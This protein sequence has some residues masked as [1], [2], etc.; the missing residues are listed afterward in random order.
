M[1]LDLV[2]KDLDTVEGLFSYIQ[3]LEYGELHFKHDPETGLKAFV[4]IHNTNLGPSLGGCRCIPYPSTANAIVDALRLAR[5]MTYKNA[6]SG[7]ALGGGKAVIIRPE[8]IADEKAYFESF[9]QFVNDL[10]G[11]YITAKDSGTSMENLDIIA[12]KTPFIA[13]TT[14]MTGENGDPSPFTARGVCRGIEAAVKFKLKRESL[15]GIHVAIQGVGG[16]GYYLALELHNRG[17]KLTIS[18]INHDAV[19]RCVEEF[20]ADVV[21]TK[22]I[23]SLECDVLTPCALGATIN[24]K[25]IPLIK[26]PIIAGGANNQLAEASDCQSLVERGI[27]FA[28]D[29][30]IN[31]GGVIHAAGKYLETPDEESENKISAIYD[32]LLTIFDRA[33][34]EQKTTCE[35]ADTMA[36]EIFQ[37]KL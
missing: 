12:S 11:R 23:H 3:H 7:L 10:N 30:V 21:D 20:N 16:V 26:A 5:G 14:A 8:K 24:K 9:G 25:S 29:Y 4:A 31:S 2:S 34:V 37:G 28:P 1:K 36:E 32:T 27:L 13:S 19:Q 33:E 15:E 35:I 18:D 17:A 22:E 6:I